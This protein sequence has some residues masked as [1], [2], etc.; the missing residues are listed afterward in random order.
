V[1]SKCETLLIV[2]SVF[3]CFGAA[4]TEKDSQRKQRED[5]KDS[6]VVV[7]PAGYNWPAEQLQVEK[8]EC[9]PLM[10]SSDKPSAVWEMK[11]GKNLIVCNLS[12]YNKISDSKIRGWVNIYERPVSDQ[13]GFIKE[14][15]SELP[16]E[17]ISFQ[18]EKKSETEI[19]ITKYILG[20]ESNFEESDG[21]AATQ[22]TINCS[23][24]KCLRTKETCVYEKPKKTGDVKILDYVES[25]TKG[26]EANLEKFGYYDVVIGK[27]ISLA[28]AGNRRAIKLVL[29][30]SKDK[31]KIDGGSAEP[32]MDGFRV[33]SSLVK[34]GCIKK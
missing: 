13:K 5:A 6:A 27:V 15:D 20:P 18:I 34:L 9:E 14:V 26:R 7:M 31:F 21:V 22:F 2:F 28:L 25:I 33:L 11:N 19:L 1:K 12:N 24:Y 29:E 3:L 30:T 17:H 8:H 32:F 4:C 10:M 16:S 23:E